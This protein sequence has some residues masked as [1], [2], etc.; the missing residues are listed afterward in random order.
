[1]IKTPRLEGLDIARFFALVGMI[2]VNF[3]MV[4]T[5][6]HSSSQSFSFA[7][8]LQG[9]AAA[10]F[11]VLAGI[12]LGLA[13][14]NKAW[15]STLTTTLKRAVFLF[16]LG[17]LN[18]LIFE[19]DIIH[20]YAVYFLFAIF[21]LRAA[22]WVLWLSMFG[23]VLGFVGLVVTLN[24]DAGWDWTTFTY[25]GFWS[26]KGFVRNMFF[27]GWHPVIPWFA[28][29]LFGIWL[30][31]IDLRASIIKRRLII[32]GGIIL[33]L[34]SLLSSWLMDAI[35]PIDSEAALLFGTSPVPPMPFYMVAGASFSC[36][37]IGVCLYLEGPCRRMKVLKIFTLPGRQTLTLYIVHILIGMGTMEAM[38][39]I[40]AQSASRAL[41]AS[42]LFCILAVLYS[43]LWSKWF[44]S[45]PLEM[46]MRRLT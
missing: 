45:G 34:V 36:V 6:G 25:S 3:D 19:P 13:S 9:R 10:S 44:S 28:F 2:I 16:V 5:G 22:N 24:Y 20:Y 41:F 11:V 32:Y 18:A 37:L 12:G 30:S 31:R 29:I 8:L 17:I 7:E 38:G 14:Q 15:N 21:F 40:G 23:L 26:P 35:E 4:M 46:L 27:N 39:L 1:M 42:A 43:F 33:L